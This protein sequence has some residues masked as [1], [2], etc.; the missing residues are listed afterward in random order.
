MHE[1]RAVIATRILAVLA[2]ILLVGAFTLATLLP[3]D[4]PLSAGLA[5]LQDGLPA[6]IQAWTNA[7]LPGWVWL[8]LALPLLTRPVWL[9]PASLGVVAAGAAATLASSATA[10][11]SRRRS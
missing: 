9:V 7:Q 3:P 4:L 5:M 2:A 10:S 8:H 6:R 11:R 1:F